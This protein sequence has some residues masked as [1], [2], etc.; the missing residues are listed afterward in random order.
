[1][2]L[3]SVITFEIH[4]FTTHIS[5]EFVIENTLDNQEMVFSHRN[6]RNIKF[7]QMFSF[8]YEK[9]MNMPLEFVSMDTWI[10]MLNESPSVAELLSV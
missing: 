3:T 10:R 5:E 4:N 7:S 2:S 1:M 6:T 8:Q 9:E